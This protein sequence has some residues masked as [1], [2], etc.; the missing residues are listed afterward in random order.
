MV[1]TPTI[2][3]KKQHAA[4]TWRAL[5]DYS[6][7]ADM[8]V[9][10]LLAS[11]VREAAR[12]FPIIFPR[13]NSTMPHALLG[14]GG[15]NIFVDEKGRWTAPYLPLLA[16]NYPFSLA[17][18]N[19]E[20]TKDKPRELAV[21]IDEKAPHFQGGG[22]PLYTPDGNPSRTLQGIIDVL[23]RQYSLYQSARPALAA[24]QAASV[25]ETRNVVIRYD[26][27]DHAVRGLRVVNREKVLAFSGETLGRWVKNGLMDMLYAHWE[28]MHNLRALLEHPS[29]P[30]GTDA[31]IQ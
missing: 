7:T 26:G 10:P 18:V 6:F 16:T 13:E 21:T 1:G 22:K 19:F 8:S 25:L 31:P 5:N 20:D 17:A 11:E 15:K 28:S 30:R 2:L 29:C 12:C 14:L 3:D 9:M 4:L 27:V 24:L 23:R